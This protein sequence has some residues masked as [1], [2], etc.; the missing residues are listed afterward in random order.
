M[1]YHRIH[2]LKNEGFSNSAI[3][4]KLGISRNTVIGY[5]EM[6]LE[7]FT[8]FMYSLQTREKKLDPYREA[9]GRF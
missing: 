2:Q 9:W 8:D 3:A 5:L 7:E 4:R 6:S 1:N